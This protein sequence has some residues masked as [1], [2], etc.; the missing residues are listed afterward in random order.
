[1]RPNP[2]KFSW[3]MV[4]QDIFIILMVVTLLPS[5]FLIWFTVKHYDYIKLWAADWTDTI[6]K[7]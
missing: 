4:V 7:L 6:F 1:M 2:P 5:C 3:I